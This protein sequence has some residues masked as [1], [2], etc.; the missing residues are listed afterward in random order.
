MKK[1]GF[2]GTGVMG[3]SIVK[4]LLKAGY[5]VNVYNRNKGRKN[6]I[7]LV[8]LVLFGVKILQCVTK[9]SEVVYYSIVGIP[10]T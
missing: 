2:I 4:H 7:E 10:L 5:E 6:R 1:I 9:K 3:S 8:F